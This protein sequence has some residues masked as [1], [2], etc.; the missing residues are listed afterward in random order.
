MSQDLLHVLR[1]AK[2]HAYNYI[3]TL[4][5]A[6]FYFSN[7]FDQIWLPHDELSPSFPTQ[8]VA[9]QK[10]M[11]TVVWNPHGFHVIQSLSKGIKW[12]GRYYSD[13]ILSQIAALRDVGSCRKMIGHADDAGLHVAKCVAAYMDY[14]SMKR[15][16]HHPSSADLAPSDF[17]I[18]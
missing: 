1:L 16:R 15:A 2:H 4:N 5:E 11:I 6:W 3:I 12:T 18:Y 14:N 10:L 9:S 17:Y 8:T 7:H 13:N